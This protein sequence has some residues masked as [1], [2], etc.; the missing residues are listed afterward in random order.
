[1]HS[2]EESG[3]DAAGA[4]QPTI[5]LARPWRGEAKPPEAAPGA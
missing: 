3:R 4:A 2:H 5:K 1:L